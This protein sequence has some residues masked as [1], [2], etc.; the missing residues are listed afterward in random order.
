MSESK[1]TIESGKWTKFEHLN[2]TYEYGGSMPKEKPI[3]IH[4]ELVS[5]KTELDGCAAICGHMP[6]FSKAQQS[7]NRVVAYLDGQIKKELKI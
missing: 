7:I 4:V 5:A 6:Q 3:N 2:G 1:T